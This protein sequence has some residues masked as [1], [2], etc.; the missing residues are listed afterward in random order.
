V[1]T[2]QL[3][4]AVRLSTSEERVM[5]YPAI[6]PR[7]PR[8]PGSVALTYHR[9]SV[10]GWDCYFILVPSNDKSVSCEPALIQCSLNELPYPRLDVFVQSLLDTQ[11]VISLCD[12]DVQ[13]AI[14]TNSKF[15]AA[16]AQH[17]GV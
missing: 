16:R 8:Q 11:Y 9:L 6:A 12:V 4:D 10:L 1:P 7:E 14:Q 17:T 5:D 2:E 3:Q 13:W 15:V